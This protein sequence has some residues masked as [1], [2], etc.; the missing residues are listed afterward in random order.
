MLAFA[1]A[2]HAVQGLT[3]DNVRIVCNMSI[4]RQAGQVYIADSHVLTPEGFQILKCKKCSIKKDK[5]AVTEMDHL[6]ENHLPVQPLS[7]ND[8]GFTACFMDIQK[9][10]SSYQDVQLDPT[11][12]AA[13]VFTMSEQHLKPSQTLHQSVQST[14]WTHNVI[15]VTVFMLQKVEL[16]FIKDGLNTEQLPHQIP[17]LQAAVVDINQQ[18]L[19][20]WSF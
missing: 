8:S 12:Q 16:T 1:S 14:L 13:D 2:I 7:W 20:C 19:Q 5:Q 6:Q 3:V 18:N 15:G 17:G 9:Y 11:L 10:L 4:V